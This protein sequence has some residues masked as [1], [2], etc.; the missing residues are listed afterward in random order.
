MD[1]EEDNT[2]LIE[3][4]V[5]IKAKN[6]D[7][8]NREIALILELTIKTLKNLKKQFGIPSKFFIYFS[9]KILKHK[10]YIIIFF[11]SEFI[12]LYNFF[13]ILYIFF[14]PVT[15]KYLNL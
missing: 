7:I 13:S 4:Y 11:L 14:V 3:R 6:P 8:E 12:D 15:D 9:K 1:K 2:V 10:K 5:K